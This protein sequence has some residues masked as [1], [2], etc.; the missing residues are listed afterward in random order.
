M[1]FITGKRSCGQFFTSSQYVGDILGELTNLLTMSQDVFVL[2]N[3]CIL[4][5]KLFC[6]PRPLYM[7]LAVLSHGGT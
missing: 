4:V 5:P 1:L 6:G 3:S 7:L 2:L